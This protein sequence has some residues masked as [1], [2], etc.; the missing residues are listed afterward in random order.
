MES[1]TDDG[2]YGY[3]LDVDI[4]YPEDL[5]KLHNDL[6][7]LA[8]N[9]KINRQQKL[10]PHFN[11]RKNYIVHHVALKHAIQHGVKVLTINRVL[12][13]KQSCWLK[14][15]RDHNTQLRTTDSSNF[16]EILYKL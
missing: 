12:R 8:E 13:F 16:E 7:F 14:S 15:Y 1:I 10:V 3:I 11:D 9:I 5:H 4:Q 2:N 6:P